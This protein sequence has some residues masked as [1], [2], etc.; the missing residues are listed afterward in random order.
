MGT[1]FVS[2]L[3]RIFFP[4]LVE[5]V[6]GLL[7]IC[8]ML[9]LGFADDVLDIRWRHKLLLPTLAS[10]PLLSVYLF[11]YGTTSIVVPRPVRFLL[12]HDVNLGVLVLVL[13]ILVSTSTFTSTFTFTWLE[14]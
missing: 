7:S 8:C 11:T 4:Q 1:N 5:F 12:G 2:Y 10:L 6:A 9:L 3:E 13:T 14:F